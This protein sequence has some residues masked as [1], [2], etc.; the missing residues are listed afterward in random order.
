MSLYH[1]LQQQDLLPARFEKE[2]EMIQMLS[3]KV[4]ASVPNK[5]ITTHLRIVA[6]LCGEVPPPPW[7]DD[8]T[9]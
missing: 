4:A 1:A 9:A 5:W 6:D 3:C 7:L 2:S 8:R